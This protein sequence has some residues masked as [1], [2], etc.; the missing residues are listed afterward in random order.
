VIGPKSRRIGMNQRRIVNLLVR[1]DD[2][3]GKHH[4]R[5]DV[6]VHPIRQ[7]AEQEADLSAE[8]RARALEMF[9]AMGSLTDIV[10][11][12]ANGH[13]V[14]DEDGAN[15]ELDAIRRELYAGLVS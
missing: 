9:G 10:I 7:Q 14:E 8:T 5:Y 12:R 4:V 2:L 13:L 3:L 6:V 1:L 15:E 11:T